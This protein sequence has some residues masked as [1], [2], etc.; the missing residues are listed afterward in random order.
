MAD[1]PPAFLDLFLAEAVVVRAAVR[2]D[3]FIDQ[4]REKG[5]KDSEAIELA[6]YPSNGSSA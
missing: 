5:C 3:T 1:D 4:L 2:M 6:D